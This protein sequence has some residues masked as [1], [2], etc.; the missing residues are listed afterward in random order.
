MLIQRTM[1][2]DLIRLAGQYPVVT[3][4]GPR[5]SGKSTLTR[6]SFPDKP[7]VS[8]EQLSLRDFALS[9]P[10]GFLNT[11]AKDGAILDEIQRVPSLLS[12]IQVRV[13]ACPELKGA[14]ILTG[15]HQLLLMES[16]TQSLAG[17]TAILKLLPFS[18]S[19]RAEFVGTPVDIPHLLFHGFYP[20]IFADHLDPVE[21]LSFYITTYVERDVREIMA[22]KDLAAFSRFLK[23][24]AGRTGQILNASSLAVDA[25]INH[26][27]ARSWLSLLEASFIITLL[28][29]HFNN[30]NKRLIKAPKLYFWDVGLACHLLGIERAEQVA[31]HPL[32]GSLFETFVVTELMKQ[33]LNRVREARLYYWRDNAG[34]E[35]DILH[36]SGHDIIP[37]EIKSGAT[38]QRDAWKGIEYYRS[39]NQKATPGVVVYG[40]SEQQDRSSG[41]RIVSFS[42]IGDL[43]NTFGTS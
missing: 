29:P 14:Y 37:I 32:V 24:C 22:I 23:L 1:Q 40:G 42:Q 10:V 16:V 33:R 25:G 13:D 41:L 36:E 19:E 17:R 35:V 2:A 8:L 11:H 3:I 12:E 30:F 7:Y 4:V 27:T 43:M 20:R 38:V 34:H 18:L 39:L 6:M 15:S 21:A 31:S 26:N 5:Q 28:Q 9:D